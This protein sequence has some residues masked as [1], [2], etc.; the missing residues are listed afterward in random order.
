VTYP[1]QAPFDEEQL[2]IL[3]EARTLTKKLRVA[4]TLALLDVIGLTA[5]GI[6]TLGL[7]ASSLELSPIGLALLVLAYNEARGRS[8]LL[9]LDRGAPIRLALNQIAL[10]AVVL[11]YCAW[12]AYATWTGPNPLET[13]AAQSGE[14]TT[15][16]RQLDAAS[17]QDGAA[18]WRWIRLAVLIGYGAVAAGSLVVQGAMA[19]YYRSLRRVVDGLARLPAW[20]RT[21]Q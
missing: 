18:L 17:G 6:A 2:R 1:A 3:A 11:A 10:F 5:F 9:A 14:L 19:Y 15:A 8:G 7:D 20:A 21:V 4:R 16:L 13:I 12:N